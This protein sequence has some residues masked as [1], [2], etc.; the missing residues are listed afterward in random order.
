MYTSVHI[1]SS[2]TLFIC[3]GKV[4]NRKVKRAITLLLAIDSCGNCLKEI[5]T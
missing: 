3:I 2:T 1:L 4:K 5:S